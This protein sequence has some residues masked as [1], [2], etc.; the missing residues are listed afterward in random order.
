M[1]NNLSV[2]I[3]ADVTGFNSAINSAQNVLNKYATNA[4]KASKEI[5]K[6]VSVTNSQVESYKRT[7][8]QL[9][10]VNSGAMTSTQQH[11]ALANQIK[12]LKIQF[13]NLSAEAKKGEFGK[14][15]SASLKAAEK[16][17]TTLDTF[18]KIFQNGTIR[19]NSV[20]AMNDTSETNILQDAIRNFK[21]PIES[22]ADTY[23]ESNIRFITS[24]SALEDSLPMWAQYGDKGTGVCLVFERGSM[25]KA[26]DL[27]HITYIRKDD[28]TVKN[29]KKLQAI[30]KEKGINFYFAL[31]DKYRNFIKYDFY[32]SED[33]YRYLVVLEKG[34][35]WTV[36]T[37]YN[38]VAPYI[39][40]SLCIGTIDKKNAHKYNFPFV[41]RRAILGPA[42]TNQK[43]NVW[44]LNYMASR[45][46]LWN[47]KV[48]PSKIDNFR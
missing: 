11:K 3:G 10:K 15:V 43:Y 19:M 38:L 5:D 35:Q 14:S 12:E 24:F 37:D 31:L 30:L 46:N 2:V 36:N 39:D 9:E 45:K 17:Y 21:E 8:K 7:I 29:I 22:E 13:A 42:M 4:K 18:T 32:K 33:E 41:L 28:E 27:L 25:F 6:N 1:A 47:F 34:E 40:R 20:V 44:Q 23:L 26:E 16:Q 48:E